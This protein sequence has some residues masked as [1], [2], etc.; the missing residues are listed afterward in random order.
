MMLQ[1]PVIRSLLANAQVSFTIAAAGEES[2]FGPMKVASIKA[3]LPVLCSADKAD[4]PVVESRTHRSHVPAEP[5]IA[6]IKIDPCVG[7][8]E[9]QTSPGCHGIRR[10]PD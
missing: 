8:C 9:N 10:T 4:Q 5:D 7:R 1:C 3:S 2:I 6:A